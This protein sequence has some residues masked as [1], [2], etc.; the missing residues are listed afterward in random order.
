MKAE[1]L[2]RLRDA[3]F[4][5]PDFRIVSDPAETDL[6]F[7]SAERFAVRSSFSGED[8]DGSSFAG[9]FDTLLNVPRDEVPA[10]VEKVLQS[11]NKENVGVYRNAMGVNGT[12]GGTV[13][14]GS[15]IIQEMVQ[16][17]LAGVLFTA[18][19][20]GLLNETVIVAGAGLGSAVVEDRAD[21]TTYYYNRDDALY[22]SESDGEAAP[23]LTGDQLQKLVELAGRVEALYGR[24]MDLEYA[25]AGDR[26]WLLQARPV[27]TLSGKDPVVLDSSNIVESYPGLTLPLSQSF[28]KE[29]YYEIF[30]ALLNRSTKNNPVVAEMDD[31]LKDMVDMANGRV[32]YRITSWYRVLNL[33]PFSDRFIAIWQEMLGVENKQVDAG[34]PVKR[35]VKLA[36]LKNVLY[37]LRTTPQEMDKLSQFYD[38][39]SA[40][41]RDDLDRLTQA[42]PDAASQREKLARLLD[43]YQRLKADIIPRW[44]IT[45]TND[46]DA[47]LFTAL[48]GKRGK[49]RLSN[50]SDLESMRPARA[51][52]ALAQTAREKG[53]D[54][55]AYA[56]AK[57]AY[58]DEY[59]DRCLGELK[60]ETRTYR[61]DPQLVDD[62]I[63]Q[64]LDQ[65]TEALPAPAPAAED[66]ER[67][68]FVRRA[69]I[70]IRNREISRLNRTRIYGIGRTIFTE[71]GKALR[72]LD[73]LDDPMDV[74]YLTIPELRDFAASG[75]GAPLP[76]P[77]FRERVRSRKE[78]YAQFAQLPAYSRLVYD[79]VIRDKQVRNLTAEDTLRGNE[80]R[81]LGV[82]AGRARG[83]AL[84]VETPDLTLNAA[85]KILVTHSTDP[86]WV[87]LIQNAS[88]IVA[89]KGS[90]LSHTAIITRELGKP[91]VVG[92]KDAVR[93]IR[94]GMLLDVDAG[95]GT[96]RILSEEETA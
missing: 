18:N 5:V 3:G 32:Y 59:G 77:S 1:N 93:R 60:L 96:V 56:S 27:T 73:L 80:L 62:Y 90:L 48:S 54:S 21:T 84:V 72:E 30:K 76:E 15:V 28:A 58:I 36:M 61:T 24:P 29:I 6:G 44:D 83:E 25:I 33:L 85:G 19:P 87:F 55:A 91:A 66:R 95:T 26:I 37:S 41:L 52:Q 23:H 71:A 13:P 34:S 70:S 17:D 51:M 63:R 8:A 10:A 75:A 49:D 22:Y 92:V 9:Q 12:S 88:G 16:P 43:K 46:M 20:M 39:Y 38:A 11:R 47:F 45:L 40:G 50:L 7:S 86:G 35:S 81:G 14:A 78:Q 57:A 31:A 94:T 89:E 42:P 82:S 53:M 65:N 69:K 67:N 64:Q 68:P 79:G 2:L 4:P 74:F